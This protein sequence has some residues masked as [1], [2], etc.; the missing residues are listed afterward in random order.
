MAMIWHQDVAADPCAVLGSSESEPDK[1]VVQIRMGENL[2]SL[3]DIGGN[4]I[5][6]VP[7]MD[8]IETRQAAFHGLI[9]REKSSAGRDPSILSL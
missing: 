3:R 9:A 5:D 1:R 6:G 8:S 4:E 7:D 2:P